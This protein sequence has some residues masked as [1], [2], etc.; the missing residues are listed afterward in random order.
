MP[1]IWMRSNA[2]CTI[3][4]NTA[5]VTPAITRPKMTVTAGTYSPPVDAVLC[6]MAAR[7][8]SEYTAVAVGKASPASSTGSRRRR[9]ARRGEY[10]EV[11]IWATTKTAEKT[12]PVKVIMPPASDPKIVCAADTG[13][14]S[15]SRWTMCASSC[16]SRKPH[17]TA[18]TFGTSTGTH[19]D[20]ASHIRARNARAG[21][22]TRAWRDP[23]W[24][25]V[26]ATW[27]SARRAEPPAASG[28]CGQRFARGARGAAQEQADHREDE[29][30]EH[31][32]GDQGS[33]GVFP[34]VALLGRDRRDGHHERQLRGAEDT[35]RE[36]VLQPQHVLV[37]Q[38]RRQ[39]P[40]HQHQGKEQRHLALGA[41]VLGQGHHVELHPARDEEEGH[42]EA[43]GEPDQLRLEGLHL[44]PTQ[45]QPHDHP[46]GK[47]AEQQIKA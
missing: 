47:A 46:G 20:C 12:M 31:S 5:S 36:P 22:P 15:S 37:E 13:M 38:K 3:A 28:W 42:Q 19:N 1:P 18:T 7:A 17:A 44:A 9:A 45:Q 33:S 8:K 2:R 10:D 6:P 16:G 4:T 24:G 35:Q 40:H 25:T 43:V 29:G 21:P 39:P 23:W 32:R 26:T 30:G 11:W 14:W 41:P 27:S 34:H